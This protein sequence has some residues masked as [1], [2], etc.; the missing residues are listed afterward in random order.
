MSKGVKGGKGLCAPEERDELRVANQRY[1]RYIRE[2]TN[3]LLEVMGTESL[4]PEEFDDRALIDLDPIGIIADSF[5]QVL[6]FL[7]QNISEL[8]QA[9]EELQAIF[10]A[11]GV[12]I[13]IIDNDF[14]IQRCNEKQRQLLVDPNLA[15]VAGRYCYEVYCNKQSPGMDCPAVDTFATGRPAFVR[16]V[17]KKEKYFQ[18]VTTPYARGEDGEV[19]KVI[20][21]SLDITEKKKA[22]AAEKEQREHYL[23]E[24]S[25]LAT[26][27][28]SLSEGLLVLDPSDRVVACNRAAREITARTERRLLGRALGELFPALVPLLARD[29]PVQGEDV[30][31]QPEK[32]GE[33]LLFTNI[34]RLLD[35]EGRSI[36]RVVTFWDITEDKKRREL[37]HRTEK[38]AAI[39]QLSAG[40]AHELNTPLGSILGYARLLMK[41]KGLAP[42]Q[43]ERL[44]I[45]AEQAKKSSAII[46][47]LLSFARHA[48]QGQQ[49]AKACDLN[50][51]IN[52]ALQ[53]L[54]TEL[55]K[56]KIELRLELE[57]LPLIVADP[58][59]LEQVVI[60]L[61]LNA[62]QAIGSRGRIVIRTRQEGG[63]VVLAV[64]DNGPGIPL[65]ARSRIF[66]PFYTT[67]PL[68]EGTGLG[69][70][71][72]AGIVGDSGGSMEVADTPGG[73]ATFLVS[74][75]GQVAGQP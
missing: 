68:G 21:V 55:V 20:E 57:P 22:E 17:K 60:N 39:G 53:I 34:S 37:Y 74:L 49:V 18:V 52:A 35:T 6:E 15:D 51:I 45:I 32:R 61:V 2:K 10:D 59:G 65:E 50:E 47:A 16:E 23:T 1:I 44:A 69:L 26:V 38:L 9:K 48:G 14:T 70:S 56:R 73:G 29:E 41:D 24:K 40:V 42:K 72:C 54:T 46:Q 28:E 75:A 4:R 12:G 64:A 62:A 27:I 31:Y 33:L 71:I 63:R 8:R 30:A 36:G 13:S 5:A 66:D 19:H 58:R 11:T 7:N 3:Q 43:H 25:K 67:K